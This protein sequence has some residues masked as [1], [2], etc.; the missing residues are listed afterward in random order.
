[1][2][3]FP[4]LKVVLGVS[5]PGTVKTNA[6]LSIGDEPK[7]LSSG[8]DKTQMKMML[9]WTVIVWNEAISR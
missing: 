8:G 2:I 9:N 5:K 7:T 1:M 4:I 6:Q 3:T